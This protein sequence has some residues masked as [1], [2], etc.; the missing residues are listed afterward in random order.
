M[1]QAEKKARRDLRNEMRFP[2]HLDAEIAYGGACLPIVIADISS[3]GVMI[4]GDMLPAAGVRVRVRAKGLDAMGIVVWTDGTQCGVLLR[5]AI[6]PLAVVRAN[7]EAFRA[8]LASGIGTYFTD[9]NRG[10]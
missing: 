7:A 8:Q 10:L 5:N 3:R 1:T 6:N 2:T 9:T 4:E